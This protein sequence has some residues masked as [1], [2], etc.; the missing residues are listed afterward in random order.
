MTHKE[1]TEYFKEVAGITLSEDQK[2]RMRETLSAYADFHTVAGVTGEP[3]E[4]L[5]TDRH[6][7]VWGLFTW[8]T[9]PMYIHATLLAAL[10]LG[11]GTAAAAESALP[12]DPLY[13]MKV[14]VNE[15]VR[16]AL[17]IGANAEATLQTELLN[18]R[19]EEAEAL[20]AE[21][22]LSGETAVL[23]EARIAAQA[24]A[25]N[26]AVLAADSETQLA[27]RTDLASA[28]LRAK[29]SAVNLALDTNAAARQGF[30]ATT[31]D[32]AV[33]S[34]ELAGELDLGTRI[35]TA[36]ERIASL[37]ALI[38]AEA[39]LGA[40]ARA[41]FASELEAAVTHIEEAEASFDAGNEAAAEVSVAE[42]ETIA[43]EIESALSLMGEIEIDPDTGT[44]IDIEVT[45]RSAL[46][47][48]L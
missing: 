15:N 46:D 32:A 47:V 3:D 39:A 8:R 36:A 21:G 22:A 44:I 30:A 31:E 11:G 38:E 33:M 42:A 24:E 18:E 34:I 29:E 14:H 45:E 12:G 20:A 4:R 23:V 17:A 9:R 19:I 16:G 1:P 27:L 13:P 10:V 28:L 5:H 6:M 48:G 35:E 2:A 40:D 41:D 7:S 26:R 43:G 37:Q 25:A